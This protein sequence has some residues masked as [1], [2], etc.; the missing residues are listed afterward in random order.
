MAEGQAISYSRNAQVAAASAKPACGAS[1]CPSCVKAGLPV[2]LTRLGLADKGYAEARKGVL[3]PIVKKLAAPD[4]VASGYVLRTLRAGYVYAYYEK[5]HTPELV[6]QHG[7]QVFRVDHGG[8]LMPI[9]LAMAGKDDEAFTCKRSESYATAMLFV[10]PQ[11]KQTKRVWVGFS[12][13]PWSAPTLKKYASHADLRAKRMA[14]IDAPA[15]KSEQAIG[16]TVEK[17]IQCIPDYDIG[18]RAANTSHLRIENR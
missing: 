18:L 5:A 14:C 15:G 1:G 9:P 3:A 8:Y 17:A 11:P 2:L 4:L 6:K 16:L 7:W 13:S 10:I 12:T